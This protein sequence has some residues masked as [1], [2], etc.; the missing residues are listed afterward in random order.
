MLIT[1]PQPL[2]AGIMVVNAVLQAN[3]VKGRILDFT[4][5]PVIGA[6]VKVVGSSSG[7]LSDLDGNYTVNAKPGDLLEIS[8]IGYKTRT[9]KVVQ[10]LKNIV[11]QEDSQN[12]N[13][14][15][16]VGFGTQK[17]VNLTGSVAVVNGE[18]L[19]QRPVQ[20]A[21]QA[22]QGI[23]PG[24]QISNSSGGSLESN[25]NIN[26]RGTATIGEGSSGS[27]LVLIDGMEGDINT[28]NPQDI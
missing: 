6:T 7:T 15:V 12:L 16:V 18:K 10:S 1:I 3:I 23:V 21:A 11:L 4:G 19:A 17:K 5:E 26:I 22:L 14:V 25:P 27:P 2:T 20:S 8:Y 28:I 13:E 9:V 24:L